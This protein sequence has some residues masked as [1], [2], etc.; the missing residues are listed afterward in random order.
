MYTLIQ[1]GPLKYG[2]IGLNSPTSMKN[3]NCAVL[4]NPS[5][6]SNKLFYKY[7][8]FMATSNKHITEIKCR[9]FIPQFYGPRCHVDYCPN[10]STN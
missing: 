10:I 9:L 4:I 5:H 1:W 6:T 2:I 7:M 3:K 8:C